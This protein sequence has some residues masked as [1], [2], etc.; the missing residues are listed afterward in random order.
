MRTASRDPAACA[1]ALAIHPGDGRR[2]VVYGELGCQWKLAE[3]K[4]YSP[5]EAHTVGSDQP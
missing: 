3:L 1:A 2:I 5:R 4:Q